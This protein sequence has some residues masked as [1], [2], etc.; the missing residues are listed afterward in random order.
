[1]GGSSDRRLR[2]KWKCRFRTGREA[3]SPN[4]TLRS[5]NGKHWHPADGQH[6]CA[7]DRIHGTFYCAWV[8][9]DQSQRQRHATGKSIEPERRY[10]TRSLDQSE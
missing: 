8:E 3:G 9:S 10:Y 7:A 4:V 5:T 1:M 2:L 6:D